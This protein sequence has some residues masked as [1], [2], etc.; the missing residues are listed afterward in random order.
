MAIVSGR[1]L[2]AALTFSSLAADALAQQKHSARAPQQ[3]PAFVSGN[4]LF[5][6]W[7]HPNRDARLSIQPTPTPTPE[8]NV[9]VP[10]VALQVTVRVISDGGSGSGVIVARSGQTYTVLTNDHVVND[11]AENG[12]TVMTADGL[13]H[14]A[15]RL[16]SAKFGDMDLALLQFT[17]SDQSARPYQV[18]AMGD[19][20]RLSIGDRVYAAGYPNWKLYNQGNALENTREG[21]LSAFRLTTGTIG[22]LPGLSLQKGYRVGYTNDIKSGMSGGPVLD[23]YGQ[24]IAINGRLKHPLQGIRAFK[25][26]DGTMPSVQLY[27]QMADLSWAIPIAT[28]Q[29]TKNKS[30]LGGVP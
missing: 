21:G 29:Q 7:S 20:Q 4:E 12:Y 3:V 6:N 27:R 8:V 22:M 15:R 17:S 26:A 10:E 30:V 1:V 25:L 11:S 5:S 23:R 24:L 2:V 28:F 13:T 9:Y 19:S 14:Q 18:A 16:R